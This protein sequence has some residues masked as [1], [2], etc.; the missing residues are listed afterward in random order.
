M[1]ENK[2]SFTD[3]LLSNAREK[4]DWGATPNPQ[5][6]SIF[7]GEF[8]RSWFCVLLKAMKHSMVMEMFSKTRKRNILYFAKALIFRC[9]P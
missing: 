2:D 7:S 9:F 6:I 8:E 5:C 3:L 4:C 1:R